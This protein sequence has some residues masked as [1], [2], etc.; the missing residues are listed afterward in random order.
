M[1]GGTRE[2]ESLLALAICAVFLLVV[3]F[4]KT[5]AFGIFALPLALLLLLE[6]ALAEYQATFQS[7]AVRGGWLFLHIGALLAAYAALIFSLFASLL[8]LM[9]ERRLKNKQKVGFL[10]WLPP[11]E[12][13][14]RIASGMLLVGFPFMT[15]GLL[16]GCLIAQESVGSGYFSDPK[17]LLSFAMWGA[18][19]GDAV[20]A[21]KHRASRAARRLPLELRLSGG[22]ERLGGKPVQR[23]AQVYDAMNLVLLGVNHKTAPIELRERLAIAPSDLAE[24]TRS[25][26]ETPGTREALILSTCNRVEFVICQE[27]A[28]SPL[29][30]FIHS[31][32][33]IDPAL[34]QPHLYEYRDEE[35]VRHLFR[36]AASLDSMVVG[37]PQILG[38]VKESYFAARSVGAVR[39]HLERLLQRAF[40]VA[41]RIRNETEI[42][43]SPV[44]V[45]SVAV[46]LAQ[47]IFGSLEQKTILLVGA[48]KMSELAARH[49]VERGAGTVLVANRTFEQAE[50]LARQFGGRAIAF[51]DLYETAD[52]ADIVIT[53]T[54]SPKAIFRKE[55]AQRFLH[56]R[57]FRPMFF[58]DIAVPRDVDPAVNRLDG[59]FLYDIDDLQSVALSHLEGRSQEAEL[60]EEMIAAEVERYQKRMYA[61]NVVPEIVQLQKVVEEIRQTELRRL[62]SRL[63]VLSA[64]QQTAVDTLTR[65]LA[66]KFLHHPLMA[67]KH[68]AREGDVAALEAIRAAFGLQ[69][70]GRYG[71]GQER[72]E[73]LDHPTPRRLSPSRPGG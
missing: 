57:R 1:P 37:E 59:I 73:G 42:G 17:V 10:T 43:A 71:V 53:S 34:I 70:T 30:E 25:L 28:A 36:V 16:A 4:Y 26:L 23:G 68:A 21:A 52:Q 67:I 7:P 55:H 19:S 20:C 8:Y 33:D 69:L 60:A 41:K 54:G 61:L 62:E 48:G 15:V 12:T 46:E 22:L 63:Q 64:E 9:Q 51:E 56:R 18:L 2:V 39:T 13:M 3:Y 44:S 50:R 65:S 35:V 14:E 32:F 29:L 5:I 45:A 58:V 27:A 11:L 31:Y 72:L 6:P 66:N 47:K 49:L 38:Q 24:A 40:A